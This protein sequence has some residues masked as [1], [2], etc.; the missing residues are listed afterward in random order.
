MSRIS[1]PFS[2]SFQ[3]S[4]KAHFKIS[5]AWR[6]QANYICLHISSFLIPRWRTRVQLSAVST[7]PT[8]QKFFC[9][10]CVYIGHK[11][12]YSCKQL[13]KLMQINFE[14]YKKSCNLRGIS[15]LLSLLSF[16]YASEDQNYLKSTILVSL[17]AL[18]HVLDMIK[19]SFTSPGFPFT[20]Q[21]FKL[22]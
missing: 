7:F 9:K 4:D 19:F 20:R 15:M 17:V 5:A 16:A 22:V 2:V 12:F 6:L 8:I 14:T 10:K 13:I 1:W 21:L 11:E 3:Q 18:N